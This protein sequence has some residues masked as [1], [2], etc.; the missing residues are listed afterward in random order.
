MQGQ[1]PPMRIPSGVNR[2]RLGLILAVLSKHVR[3]RMYRVDVH[4][5]VVGGLLMQEPAT[6]LAIAVAIVSSYF[7]MPTPRDIAVIGEIGTPASLSWF[8]HFYCLFSRINA[9]CLD[10]YL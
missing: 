6:D 5:N 3:L 10:I 1:G 8:L 7:D 4:T 9:T 2:N